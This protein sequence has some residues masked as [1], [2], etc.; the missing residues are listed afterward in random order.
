M[1]YQLFEDE[2]TLIINALH[3]AASEYKRCAN[4]SANIPS[5]QEQFERQQKQAIALAERLEQGECHA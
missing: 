4:D 3:T 5:L 1:K 2:V